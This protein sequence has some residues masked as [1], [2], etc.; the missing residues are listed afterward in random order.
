MRAYRAG[1]GMRL[2]ARDVWT[3]GAMDNAIEACAAMDDE[4][5]EEA[6]DAARAATGGEPCGNA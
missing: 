3:L 2:S 6:A 4:A 1:T 5:D